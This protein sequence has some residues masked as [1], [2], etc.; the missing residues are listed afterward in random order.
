MVDVNG[1]VHFVLDPGLVPTSV[2][3]YDLTGRE[4]PGEVTIVSESVGGGGASQVRWTASA[5]TSGLIFFD[6]EGETSQVTSHATIKV[7]LP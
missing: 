1:V 3:A 5:S 2:R 6:I 4:I 7:I